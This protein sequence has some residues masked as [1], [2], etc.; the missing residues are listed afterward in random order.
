M[1]Q[2][3][4]PKYTLQRPLRWTRVINGHLIWFLRTQILM[5]T[6]EPGLG[7]IF[8]TTIVEQRIRM[9]MHLQDSVKCRNFGYLILT[10]KIVENSAKEIRVI[11][12][13]NETSGL[14]DR[15]F[16]FKISY[17]NLKCPFFY[18]KEY[19]ILIRIGAFTELFVCFNHQFL[20]IRYEAMTVAF[21]ITVFIAKT[22]S[23]PW[24]L[25]RLAYT[26]SQANE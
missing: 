22:A 1:T 14:F 2:F 23:L 18:K 21:A 13:R 12:I 20:S 25:K 9:R 3:F 5:N 24:G 8:P 6:Y 17:K 4:L 10:D 7:L 15:N 11:L 26:K 16:N 19:Y